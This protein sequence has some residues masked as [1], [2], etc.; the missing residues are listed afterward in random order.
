M[1]III[2]KI[3]TVVNFA[4]ISSGA[5]LQKLARKS[6]EKFHQE[7]ADDLNWLNKNLKSTG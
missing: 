4:D 7:K 3:W 2:N 5:I 6:K 1:K